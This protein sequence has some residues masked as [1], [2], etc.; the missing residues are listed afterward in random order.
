MMR[1]L[2]IINVAFLWVSGCAFAPDYDPASAESTVAARPAPFGEAIPGIRA[3]L[4][5]R[6]AAGAQVFTQDHTIETGLGPVFNQASCSACHGFPAVG[7][8]GAIDAVRF[9]R[10]NENGDFDPMT[11]QGGDVLQRLGIATAGC[12]QPG[13]EV[14]ADASVVALRQTQPLFGLGYLEAIPEAALR[15]LADPEDA[16]GD[17]V[18]GRVHEV[19]DPATGTAGV[20]RFGWKAEL[21]TLLAFA[22]DAS[23]AELGVSN[24]LFPDE[25][26]PQ[27]QS[28]RCDDSIP[29]AVDDADSDGDGV[30]DGIVQMADFMRLLAVPPP[31]GPATDLTRVGARLFDRIGCASCHVPSLVTAA[32]P[33]I[34]Q[35][36]RK[37]IRPYTD[38]L[39]HDMGALGDGVVQGDAQGAEFRTPP[40]WGLR[41][42][43]PYLHN[44]LATNLFEAIIFHD[45][46][47]RASR[48]AFAN[49]DFS[50]QEALL[51]FLANL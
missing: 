9:G 6:F 24:T 18:S 48:D 11:A 37:T 45:G 29:H 40:L 36:S 7:G 15:A 51:E 3:S 34:P 25:L 47:A 33:G 10:V 19:I 14:P 46:E 50:E 8:S 38:L 41:E 4:R 22:G 31:A 44:G 23:L 17:G 16:D 13:E 49:L 42:T 39:L 21:P 32:V 2:S 12:E 26:L 35:L 28:P 27:G 1:T 30:S 43:E 20:G 5:A